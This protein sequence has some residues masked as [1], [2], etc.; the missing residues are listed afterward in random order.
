MWL[1]VGVFAALGAALGVVSYAA[2]DWA[3]VQFASAASGATLAEF[4]PVFVSLSAFQT[5]VTLFLAGPVVGTVVGVLVGSRF[6]DWRLAGGVAGGGSLVGFFVMAGLGTFGLSL[7]GGPGTE[8]IYAV[9]Q[10][11]GPLLVAGVATGVVGGVSGLLGS[12]FVR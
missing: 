8:Q 5:T 10:A 9:D 7:V 4:G 12:A 2:T 3:R 1:V 11:I 6:L